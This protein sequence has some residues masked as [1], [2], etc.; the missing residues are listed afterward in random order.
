MNRH[1]LS[2]IAVLFATSAWAAETAPLTSGIEPQ[3]QDAA[4][5]IQDDFYTHVNGTWMKNTEIPADK[6]A[7][8]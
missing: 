1:L 2:A 4:V 8:G 7:W 3:Y 5:R 6:S